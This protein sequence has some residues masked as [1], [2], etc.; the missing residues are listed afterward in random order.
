MIGSIAIIYS[1]DQARVLLAR[2]SLLL[3]DKDWSLTGSNLLN[4]RL[5]SWLC[6]FTRSKLNLSLVYQ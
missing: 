3:L 6:H 1:Y 5:S 4:S 2:L